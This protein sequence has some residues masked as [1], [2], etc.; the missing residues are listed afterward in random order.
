[1]TRCQLRRL[2]QNINVF[3][4]LQ[5]VCASKRVPASAVAD[6]TIALI[7]R[8]CVYNRAANGRPPA[9][10]CRQDEKGTFGAHAWDVRVWPKAETVVQEQSPLPAVSLIHGKCKAANALS[11]HDFADANGLFAKVFRFLK[12]LTLGLSQR[13]LCPHPTRYKLC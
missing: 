11:M 1:M 9:T 6:E 7:R 5:D 8:L 3:S 12:D 13:G 10:R 2:R 4:Y